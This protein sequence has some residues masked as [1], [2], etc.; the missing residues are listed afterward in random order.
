MK[1][2]IQEN[3]P[4]LGT[5][6]PAADDSTA[7]TPDSTP[8][9]GTEIPAGE[10]HVKSVVTAHPLLSLPMQGGSITV[11][12]KANL[13]LGQY[14]MIQNM[15]GQHPGF[16]QR[17]GQA[18]LH[19]TADGS[20]K[21]VDIFQFN[22]TKVS[23]DH[24]LALFS[25]GDILDAT[26]DPP[27]VA[28][29]AVFGSQLWSGTTAPDPPSWSIIDDKMLFA[30][31]KDQH[32][33]YA[34]AGSYVGRFM[35]YKGSGAPPTVP[36]IGEDFST[37]VSDGTASVAVLDSLNT[38]A[39]NEMVF[40]FS[41]VP[42]NSLTWTVSAV[43][44][45]ASTATLYY[46][47]DDNTWADTSMSDGTKTGGNT[48]LGQTGSMTWTIPSD[49]QSSYMYGICGFWYQL[50]VS[51]QLDAEVEVSA[52]TY[53]APFQDLRNIWDGVP[54]DAVEVQVEGTT[55]YA[56][57]AAGAVNVNVLT[58]GKKMVVAS[59]DPIEG[60]YID[61]GSTP[62]ATGTSIASLKY[63]D[64]N[65]FAMATPYFDADPTN[66]TFVDGGVSA[67]TLTDSGSGFVT[68][69]FLAGSKMAISGATTAANDGVYTIVSVAAGTLTF[70]TASW[71][72]AEAGKAAMTA[73]SLPT[74]GTSGMSSP[75]W[76]T[77]PRK[78]AYKHQFG[79]STFHAFWYEIIWDTTLSADMVIYIQTMPYFDIGEFGKVGVTSAVWNNRGVYS[80]DRNPEYLYFSAVGRPMV[81]NGFDYYILEAG[82]GRPNKIASMKNFYTE[83]QVLQEEEGVTGGTTTL[84]YG[85]SQTIDKIVL[86]PKLGTLNAKSVDVVDGVRATAES[87]GAQKTLSFFISRLGICVSNGQAVSIISDD[88]QNY[89]DP[90]KTECIRR[91]YEKE[92]WLAYD[93]TDIVVRC[94]LVSGTSA[95][96][97]NVFPVYDLLDGSWY[98]D[99]PAQELSCMTEVEAASGNVNRIQVGGGT[100]DGFVY[101]L[102]TGTNDVS[103]AI[104]AYVQVEIDADGLEFDVSELIIRMKT[105]AAGNITITPYINDQGQ[106]TISLSMT[107]ITAGDATRRHRLF[108][109]QIGDHVSL[110]LQNATGSQELYIES[111]RLKLDSLNER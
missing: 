23:D 41:P 61:P 52:V 5:E 90:E 42:I 16:K 17:K 15:R 67:D 64:G 74:D 11:R 35:I 57:Y 62:N 72:T 97:P 47:K 77:F 65:S 9:L 66:L 53:S 10:E 51:A 75:G 88:I 7:A 69:G 43:N 33:I 91:G 18:K 81:L 6:I 92:M 30:N 86:S 26:N 103:T 36:T 84:F 106:T 80:F 111:L 39:N 19:G 8:D 98:F 40:I 82:D 32:Q 37:E 22:K 104:D 107:V 96:L 94:G 102:N 28:T 48:T 109:R 73:I 24:F 31:G 78:T 85:D 46:K 56:R 89:F 76:I 68:D 99:T 108:T 29:G 93:S 14:S 63:W 87:Q 21:V 4:D 45:T 2:I 49:E 50:R 83:L 70:A 105:Q 44:G 79:T 95:T 100:N 25:D 54:A 110:K 13:R 59:A 55:Q 34:G 58:A 3:I 101:R 71:D 1:R 27:T 38:Y 20:N 60:I 12:E